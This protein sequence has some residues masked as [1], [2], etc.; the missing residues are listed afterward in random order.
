MPLN[1]MLPD[2]PLRIAQNKTTTV[3]AQSDAPKATMF[4]V[5]IGRKFTVYGLATDQNSASIDL[6]AQHIV[7]TQAVAIVD[8]T[9]ARLPTDERVVPA[10]EVF[11]AGES[12]NMGLRNGTASPVTPQ[13]EVY[14]TDEP[15]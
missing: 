14:Y 4:T 10:F 9:T 15:A 12:L 5:P 1:R 11:N 8:M 3:G 7:G 2:K 6:L 13:L